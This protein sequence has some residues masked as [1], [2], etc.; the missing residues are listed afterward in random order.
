MTRELNFRNSFRS[1]LALATTWNDIT[2]QPADRVPLSDYPCFSV[3]LGE[4][5]FT[6]FDL[7]GRP[8]IGEQAFTLT[9]YFIVQHN[10]LNHQLSLRSD[11]LLTLEL[12]TNSGFTPPAVGVIDN[13][14]IDRSTI[15]KIAPP[16]NDKDATRH[17]IRLDCKYYFALF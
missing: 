5:R 13:Y 1:Q 17:A 14:R 2:E 3:R 10:D 15:L 6:E 7:N 8:I 11:Y 12:F 16:S 4:T 9:F